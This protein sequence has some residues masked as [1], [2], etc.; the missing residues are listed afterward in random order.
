MSATAMADG[1]DP[2]V[3][4][5]GDMYTQ[6]YDADSNYVHFTYSV[7]ESIVRFKK[8]H[9]NGQLAIWGAYDHSFNKIGTWW[10]YYQDGTVQAEGHYR[11]GK[12]VKIWKAYDRNGKL[13][14]HVKYRRNKMI[15]GW[16]IVDGELMH[17]TKKDK[18]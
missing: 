13:V 12:K 11:E 6:Y 3:L 2:I 16:M 17:K 14:M 15:D 1:G 4:S 8:Y 5:V 7:D 9:P 10:T 18:R